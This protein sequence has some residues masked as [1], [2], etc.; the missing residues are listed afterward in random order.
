MINCKR[1]RKE[2][3]SMNLNDRRRYIRSLKEL[4]TNP[5]YKDLFDSY[6]NLHEVNFFRGL[7]ESNQFLPWHR[8][9]LLGYENLLRL[10]DCSLTVPVWNW[11][12][13]S[14]IAWNQAS[15]YHMWDEDGGFGGNGNAKKGF[16]VDN[17]EFQVGKWQPLRY[18]SDISIR[19][20][21]INEI[22]DEKCLNTT[23]IS[24]FKSCLRRRFH[25]KL[26]EYNIVLKIIDS[27]EDLLSF[28]LVTRSYWHSLLH[29]IIGGYMETTYASFAPEFWSHHAMLD[30]A[31]Y[32]WQQKDK[33][34]IS[35][36]FPGTN[37]TLLA[38]QPPEL[39]NNYI[40]SK[41]LGGCGIQVAYE[42]KSILP[43]KLRISNK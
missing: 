26:P 43:I 9:Y 2:F 41:S 3:S 20:C 29:N 13:F 30:A 22:I 10:I 27:V 5:K 35:Q 1:V 42:Q 17:G 11:A 37:N 38:F 21:R 36:K 25:G 8:K 16:C 34:R 14:E 40:N 12:Y 6:S 15:D 4:S 23:E 33:Q 39:R 32:F 18:S 31:W 19:T 24:A 7:H 28:E